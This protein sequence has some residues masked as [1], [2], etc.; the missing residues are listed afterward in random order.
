VTVSAAFASFL[1]PGIAALDH[2]AKH[3]EGA[4]NW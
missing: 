3:L 4:R 2:A 1:D